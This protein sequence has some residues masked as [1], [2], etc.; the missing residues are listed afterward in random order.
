ML[1]RAYWFVF[2]LALAVYAAMAVWTL[3]AI[4]RGADGLTPFDLR[5][6]GY[7]GDAARAF[8]A[9]LSDDARALYLGPQRTLDR[10]YPAMLALV[11]LGAIRALIGAAWLRGL[12]AVAVLGGMAADYVENARVAG[13]L[14]QAGLVDDETV[15]AASRAT[16]VKSALTS[17]V[18]LAV[19]IGLAR[20]L[21]KWRAE[22]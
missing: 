5:F 12:L 19:V 18:M 3:P 8:I 13:M 6:A 11:L 14:S 10:F 17:V 21:A 15:A 20:R 22:R 1:A 16:L 7:D 9:A 4:T 2:A